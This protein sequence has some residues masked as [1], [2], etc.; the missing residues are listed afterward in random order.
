M[1]NKKYHS[2]E[3]VPK[4]NRTFIE[5]GKIITPYTQIVLHIYTEFDLHIYII[6]NFDLD[7][8]Q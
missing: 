6:I 4:F 7:T 1:E 3:T 2:V 5:R 8:A